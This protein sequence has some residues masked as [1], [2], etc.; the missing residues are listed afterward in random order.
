[1][2]PSSYFM[3]FLLP[4]LFVCVFVCVV[5]CTYTCVCLCV[6]ARSQKPMN[7]SPHDFLRQACSLNLVLTLSSQQPPGASRLCLSSTRITDSSH[8]NWL[9]KMWVL[10]IKLGLSCLHN[11]CLPTEPSISL[12][13]FAPSVES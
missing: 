8:H 11:M 10:G 12:A 3:K 13:P 5:G 4:L 7:C 6:E 2:I 9:Y 1:M